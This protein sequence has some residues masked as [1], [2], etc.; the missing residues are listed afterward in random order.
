MAI[1]TEKYKDDMGPLLD[2]WTITLLLTIQCGTKYLE[3]CFECLLIYPPPNYGKIYPYAIDDEVQI[4]TA[5]RYWNVSMQVKRGENG[6]DGQVHTNSP[7]S[8]Q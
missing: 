2:F 4:N 8:W 6:E 7:D 5:V 1:P 3:T